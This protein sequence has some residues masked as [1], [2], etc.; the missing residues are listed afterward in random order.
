MAYGWVVKSATDGTPKATATGVTNTIQLAPGQYVVT[1]N[2]VDNTG[3]NSQQGPVRFMV[4][5]AGQLGGPAGIGPQ[6]VMMAVIKSPPQVVLSGKDGGNVSVP[7]D[8]TGSLPAP[9]FLVDR[10]IWTVQ[11]QQAGNQVLLSQQTV[12]QANAATVSLP[13]GSYIVT[14]TV[15]DTGGRNSTLTKV[16]CVG[17]SS[18]YSTLSSYCTDICMRVCSRVCGVHAITPVRLAWHPELLICA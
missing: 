8:A 10:Y 2:V 1:L 18:F 12:T 17:G 6:P 11:T 14:L 15:V 3:A 13:V 16:G 9:G 5:G 7:L 4:T